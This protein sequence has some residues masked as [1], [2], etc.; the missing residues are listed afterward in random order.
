MEMFAEYLKE[1][2]E[3][4]FPSYKDMKAKQERA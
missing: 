4:L 2:P 1:K 3:Q